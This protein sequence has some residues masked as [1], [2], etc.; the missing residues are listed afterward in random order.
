MGP[1]VL[2][3]GKYSDISDVSDRTN[4]ALSNRGYLSLSLSLSC[5]SKGKLSMVCTIRYG[6]ETR[7]SFKMF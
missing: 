5:L 3:W 4:V 6:N 1:V 2:L 7:H